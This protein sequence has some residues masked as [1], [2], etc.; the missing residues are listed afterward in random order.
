M[1]QNV[2][3]TTHRLSCQ[4]NGLGGRRNLPLTTVLALPDASKN[5]LD[6]CFDFLVCIQGPC[7]IIQLS[8]QVDVANRP[9]L[10]VPCSYKVP[11]GAEQ[12][13]EV[14]YETC[15]I[16]HIHRGDLRCLRPKGEEEGHYSVY[17]TNN[18]GQNSPPDQSPW[19]V[20]D[21]LIEDTAPKDQS[22]RHH[23]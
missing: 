15:P 22:D 9:M 3:V 10:I 8:R 5:R 14:P 4:F 17:K 13:G 20:P 12:H 7:K 16:I 1:S 19:S 2:F 6:T 11:K 18:V 23:V 21:G